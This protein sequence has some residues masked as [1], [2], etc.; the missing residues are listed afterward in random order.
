MRRTLG[1]VLALWLGQ[2]GLAAAAFEDDFTAALYAGK[3]AE[4]AALAEAA[5]AADQSNAAANAAL[6]IAQFLGGVEGMIQDFHRYG[7]NN[8]S[9]GY[10]PLSMAGLPFLRLPVPDNLDPEPVTYAALRQILSDFGDDLARAEVTLA[11]VDG[12]LAI[13]LDLSKVRLDLDGDGQIGP[14]EQLLAV[15]GAVAGPVRMDDAPG[16][17]TTDLDRTDTVWLRAYTHLLMAMTDFLLAHDWQAAYHA[18]FEGLF[19]NSFRPQTV[20]NDITRNGRARVA[21]LQQSLPQRPTCER[22][23]DGK[24]DSECDAK[25]RAFENNAKVLEIQAIRNAAEYGSIADIVAFVHLMRW[26]VQDA[27]RLAGSLAHLEQMIVLSRQMWDLALAETDDAREWLPSPKQ[28]GIF[29][30]LPIDQERLAGWMAFLDTFDAVL[31]GEMLLPHWRFRQGF[32]LRAMFLQPQTFD[33]VMMAHGSGVIAYLDDGP[34]ADS[35]VWNRAVA[36]FG[37]DF[38]RYFVFIN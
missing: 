20:L 4:A 18:T 19:P 28:T 13:T 3:T 27:D 15:F 34:I 31:K 16:A 12:D 9:A 25:H 26:P 37:G 2:T 8:G 6:G 29:R 1:L 23:T 33:P 7:L 11:G 38:F 30:S 5:I 17:W 22:W 32:D 35:G 14:N 24:V 10:A 36:V 21:E